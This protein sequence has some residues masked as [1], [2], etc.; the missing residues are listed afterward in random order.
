[1]IKHFIYVIINQISSS[2]YFKLLINQ[3]FIN[4]YKMNIFLNQITQNHIYLQNLS[5]QELLSE[6][7]VDLANGY[8]HKFGYDEFIEKQ[9]F[10]F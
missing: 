4:I 10:D 7:Y 6:F 5:K 8:I 1:M 2:Y 3:R 9:F